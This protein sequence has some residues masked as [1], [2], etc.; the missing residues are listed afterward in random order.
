MF[1]VKRSLLRWGIPI[2]VLLSLEIAPRAKGNPATP[3]NGKSTPPLADQNSKPAPDIAWSVL[4][5]AVNSQKLR[6]RSDAISA[7]TIL[8][9]D[10]R[11]IGIVSHALEDKEETIRV[12]AATSLGDMKALSAIPEL[13]T[14]LD[15]KSP[16]VS[17][18]AAQALW[19]MGNHS[20]RDIFY[21]VLVGERKTQP[22]PIKEKIQKARL[23]M[24]N[25][26]TLALIGINEASSAFLGPFSMGISMAEEYA[27][28]SGTSVQAL[29][30]QLLSSDDTPNTL[31]QLKF[32]LLDGNW[33]VRAAAA[34]ALARLRVSSALPQLTTMMAT[35]KSQPA[36]LAAAAA[37]IEVGRGQSSVNGRSEAQGSSKRPSQPERKSP[38]AN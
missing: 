18:A 29:C 12:I 2:L 35:E 15:D 23:D 22:G 10:R 36:R 37:V 7:L 5:D 14:A 6:D 11:A 30:A 34:R 16:Q 9:G 27:N 1:H 3:E 28:N 25:P 4:A 38:N 33:V 20:G 31:E 17:F 19:K 32:A 13:K 26:K 8:A 21:D 24:H